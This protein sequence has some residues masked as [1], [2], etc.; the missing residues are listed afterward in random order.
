[1]KWILALIILPISL[2]SQDGPGGIDKSK[3]YQWLDA[4]KGLVTTAMASTVSQ[5]EDQSGQNNDVFQN[6]VYRQPPALFNVANSY[7]LVLFD[8]LND[9]LSTNTLSSNVYRANYNIFLVWKASGSQS[10]NESVFSTSSNVSSSTMQFSAYTNSS[11]FHYRFGNIFAGNLSAYTS[12]RITNII[13]TPTDLSIGFNGFIFTNTNSIANTDARYFDLLRYGANRALDRFLSCQIS[14]SII[15]LTTLTT[16]ERILVS[17]YLAAKY[18]IVLSA[19]DFYVQDNMSAGDFDHNVAGIGKAIDGSDHTDSK[20]TGI[21]EIS[22]PSDLQNDEFLFWGEGIKNSNYT[23]SGTT[24]YTERLSSIWRVSKRNDVGS[25]TLSVDAADLDLSG[26]QSCAT[27]FVI[28]SSSSSF[29]SKTRYPMTLNSGTY[30]ATGVSFNDDDYFTFE[31]FDQIVV[32]NSQFYNGAGNSNVPNTTDACYKFLVKNSATGALPL[33]E[34]AIVKEIEVESGG[35]LTI[36]SDIYVSLAG[37]IVNNG[38]INIEENTSLIQTSS[39]AD[40]NSGSGIYNVKRAGNNS[41]YIYNIWASPIQSATLTSV[42]NSANPCDIWTFDKDN[43]AWKYDFAAG[44][45]TTC[46]GNSVTFSATDVITGGDGIMDIGGGYFV[47]GDPTALK[48]Y[49]GDINNGDIQKAITTTSLGNPGGTG[50]AGDDWNLIGNPYPSGLNA[51]AFW[52]ENAVNNSRISDGLYFW[53]E[54]D[55][56]GGYNQYS[57][58]ASWNLLGGVNSGNSSK[59]PNGHIASGQ[60]F[61][62]VANLTTNVVFNNGMR[63]GNNNQFFKNN[64]DVNE[65]SLAWIN[66]TSPSG[67]QNNILLGYN[68][69]TTDSIDLG[70]DAHKLIGNSHVELSSLINNEKFS[71]QAF[72]PLEIGKVKEIPIN[73]VT[74]ETGTHSIGMYKSENIADDIGIYL[75]DT[76]T[77]IKHDLKLENYL[78]NLDQ[79]QNYLTRFNILFEKMIDENKDNNSSKDVLGIKN[80]SHKELHNGGYAIIN[81]NGDVLVKNNDGIN[82]DLKLFD[83]TGRM[84]W[85]KSGTSDI[86]HLLIGGE[87]VKPGIYLLLISEYD[88]SGLY[89]FV[90]KL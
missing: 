6:I 51:T 10:L 86:Q 23:F 24:D 49:N 42:F 46:N 64:N 71:I 29:S 59:I 72:A 25:V 33:T 8:G 67:Y 53:D 65:N 63:S 82:A 44:Y 69:K 31:Y 7:P 35:V 13:R 66:L 88:H 17:N 89:Q 36:N 54:A 87:N 83:V 81:N 37:D 3:L 9:Y 16:I 43:Q 27:L 38:T 76:E 79:N 12:L 60:G 56:T 84:V 61:W 48:T 18:D 55:T 34:N 77:N 47:P 57:D 85:F 75:W 5:W 58:Y 52:N 78:V 50:W 39:G 45:S 73:I 4:N 41:S 30:T 28:V 14:E 74:S 22:N 11:P 90:I 40:N 32:D 15:A 1:M 19:N 20:G 68:S 80:A 70:Y 62:V 26:K 2:C 21:I